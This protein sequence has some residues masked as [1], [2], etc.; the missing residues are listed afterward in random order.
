MADIW[1]HGFKR[2]NSYTEEDLNSFPEQVSNNELKS[3]DFGK[4][5]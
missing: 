5:G 2:K 4:S 1:P 3:Q